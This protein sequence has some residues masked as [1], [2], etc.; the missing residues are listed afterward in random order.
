MDET[1]EEIPGFSPYPIPYEGP[2][3]CDDNYPCDEYEV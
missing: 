3:E 1:T 2:E